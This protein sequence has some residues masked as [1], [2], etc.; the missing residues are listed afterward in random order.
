M[1]SDNILPLATLCVAL[2]GLPL[3]LELAAV[4]LRDLPPD[5]L[6]QQLLTLRG[7]GRLSSTWLQQ[8]KRNIAE[9]HRTLQAAIGWSVRMLTPDQRA[10]FMRLGVFAGGCSDAAAEAVTGADAGMLAQLAR[11]NLVRYSEGRV[12]LLET[13]RAFAY[14]Q[15]A[16]TGQLAA[17]QH[18]HAAHCAAFTQ[19]VFTGLLGDDQAAWMQRALADHNNCLAALRWALA[20][21]DGELAIALAGRLWWFW[22]RRGLLELGREM[23]AAA[24][25][26]TTPDLAAR[27]TALNG[28]ASIHLALD[29]YADSLA[30]HR[31]GLA[32]RDQ[33]GDA[34]GK[35]SVLHNMGLTAYM[36]GDYARAIAWLTESIAA[37]PTD[38]PMQAWAHMGIIALDMLDVPQARG[39]LERAYERVTQQPEGWGRAFVLH[40]LADA[41]RAGGG[42]GGR[43][44]DGAGQ[45]ALVRGVG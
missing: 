5:L 15:L 12:T 4:R 40:N 43:E 9:R 22:Y 23:L 26:L 32:L 27:A 10:A 18:S 16:D 21:A 24:L 36:S 6:A 3:A 29:E 35:A 1:T 39:W 45:P 28:L 17:C 30:C 2:D 37:D 8:D 13:L 31:E 38:D 25:R 14:E 20:T 34:P 42:I 33:L 19:Q 41:L 11:A 7:H 44:G